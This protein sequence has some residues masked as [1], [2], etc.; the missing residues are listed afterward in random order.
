MAPQTTQHAT[1]PA[2][3]PPAPG[4]HGPA[5]V[6]LKVLSDRIERFGGR[7]ALPLELGRL[8]PTRSPADE[9][10][11]VVPTAR[12]AGRL[13]IAPTD[14]ID[15]SRAQVRIEPAGA[16]AVRLVNQS[17]SI[18]IRCFE[19][20][21][22]PPGGSVEQRL[23]VTLE[24][25]R[26][27]LEL[28]AAGMGPRPAEEAGLQTLALPAPRLSEGSA[29]FQKHSFTE[30]VSALQPAAIDGL[31]TWWRN[32]IGVL[33]SAS[34][35]DDFFH[36][37]AEAIVKLV[38]L[39]VGAV[40][41]HQDGDWRPVALQSSGIK[42]ARPSKTLLA[43]V[44]DEKRTFWNRV[45]GSVDVLSSMAAI[46]AYV[47]SP[48]LDREGRV[49][50]ALYGHRSCN[51]VAATHADITSLE[52]LLVETL[53]CGVAGGL[54]RLEQERSALAQKVQ[55]EQFFTPQLAGELEVNPDLLRGRDADVTVLFCDI[56]NF[57]G[58]TER[59]GP[60]QTMEWVGSV[61]S[62]LSDEVAATGGVLVDY[63]GDELMAMWGAPSPQADHAAR[64][65]AA[66]RRMLEKIPEIND[67]W[68][69]EID[70]P[71]AVG[72]GINSATA[73]VGNTGST[74][75]FKYGPLGNGVNLASRVQGATKYLRVP[76]MITGSTRRHLDDSYLVR[77]LCTVRVVNI[78]EP[79]ELYELDDAGGDDRRALFTAYDDARSAFDEGRFAVAARA[80]GDLLGRFPNDGPS[81]LLLSR[82]VENMLDEPKDFSPV[83]QLPG[84]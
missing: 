59:L 22:V 71:T 65:C 64:A 40:F 8:D 25:G 13:A 34:S 63:I 57:S 61:L 52:A 69:R 15:I 43:K 46:E 7:V 80:L 29:L 2:H 21:A 19:R 26:V 66:A 76:L 47:A 23:P 55:F 77:R 28:E 78:V 42:T 31:V 48:I 56:R 33:Q 4:I 20:P 14:A 36:K 75:K 1:Q 27:I 44:L 73:R 84:K 5:A 11:Q 38:R 81:L 16:G 32:V 72:I 3:A 60:A 37:A 49:I 9:L 79:V 83:W 68:Q 45:E 41:L 51:G 10:Y 39:D 12:A 17:T 18:P 82:A 62:V 54:A 58:I 6:T 30:L 35:S 53:A 24:I 67:R 74:R 50:G 70:C